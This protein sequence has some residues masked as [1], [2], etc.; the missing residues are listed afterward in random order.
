MCVDA[1]GAV[2]AVGA[3]ADGGEEEEEESTVLALPP[4]ATFGAA[5]VGV[6]DGDATG[7]DHQEEGEEMKEDHRNVVTMMRIRRLGSQRRV[8]RGGNAGGGKLQR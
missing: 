3:V 5:G 6:G 2:G 4:Q 8:F 7:K 1:V